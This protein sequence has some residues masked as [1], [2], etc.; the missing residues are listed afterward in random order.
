V[1]LG[2]GCLYL[3]NLCLEVARCAAWLEALDFDGVGGWLL[4]EVR[5]LECLDQVSAEGALEGQ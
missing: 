3:R 4:L 5:E 2:S 1:R